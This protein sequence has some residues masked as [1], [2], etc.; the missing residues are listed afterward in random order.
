MDLVWI[1]TLFLNIISGEKSKKW[2]D[3][4]QEKSGIATHNHVYFFWSGALCKNFLEIIRRIL[5]KPSDILKMEVSFSIN[6]LLF[7]IN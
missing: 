7:W 3:S 2:S 6:R 4:L 5:N 1:K